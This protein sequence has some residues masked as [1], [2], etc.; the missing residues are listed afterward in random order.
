MVFSSPSNITNTRGHRLKL[1]K[2]VNG[3][4]VRLCH[5]IDVI[6][7]VGTLYLIVFLSPNLSIYLELV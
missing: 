6:L 2:T 1:S 5:F 3:N 7:T 4:T